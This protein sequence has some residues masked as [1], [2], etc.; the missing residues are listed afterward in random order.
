MKNSI[1]FISILIPVIL[2][3]NNLYAQ[4]NSLLNDRSY[5]VNAD[6]ILH[7]NNVSFT[8][9]I[10]KEQKLKNISHSGIFLSIGGGLDVPLRNFHTT[11]NTSFGILGRLEFG[12]T[13]IFPFVPGVEIDYFSYSGSDNFLTSL[14]LN[15]FQT[16]ILSFGVSLE[17][18]LSRLL[19]SS[20]TIPFIALDVK[21]NNIKR[22]YGPAG[23]ITGYPDTES[24]ISIGAGFGFTLFV[25][26]FV[27]KY[28]YMKDLSNFGAYAK[29]KF[30]VIQF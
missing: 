24:R 16:K 19:N 21:T 27:V 8:D 11:S 28:N 14:L 15:S 10:K 3:C 4:K 13:A 30:P 1:K 5:R 25:F 6:K 18:T 2:S 9:T 7:Q 12:S 26:D 22:Q 29:I 17:Y 20:Y 23:T